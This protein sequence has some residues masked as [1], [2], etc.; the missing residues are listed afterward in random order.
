VFGILAAA[1]VAVNACA[2]VQRVGPATQERA[3]RT[4]L[5]SEARS[6]EG[7]DTMAGDPRPVWRADVGRGI[8][9]G[10]ALTEDL[11]IVAMVDRQ[12]V[13]LERATGD[14]LWRRRLPNAPGAGPLAD[15]DR[16]VVA[17]Q[18][19]D[20]R[21]YALRLANGARIWSAAAGD[22][23]APLVMDDSTVYAATTTGDVLAIRTSDGRRLWRTRLPGAVRAAPL[24]TAAGLVVATATDSLFLLDPAGGRVLVRAGIRGS[25]LA[26][27]TL[28][29]PLVV[30]GTSAGDLLALRADSLTPH[31][32]LDLGGAVAGTVAVREGVAYAL[33]ARG[34]LWHV[35]LDDPRAAG[36][37][38]TGVTAR[39]GPVPTATGVF[40]AGVEGE[41][42]LVDPATGIRRWSARVQ[43]PLLEPPLVDGRFFLVAAARGRVVAF[44]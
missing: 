12:I 26:A 38:E 36:H 22:V 20:G 30:V 33:T 16:I 44:R 28:A 13:V 19:E 6:S 27:P 17:T 29:G 4:Y 24:P 1:L 14:V 15:G 8:V 21:V 25:V 42:A 10:P 11:V 35:P 43:S 40:V 18:E 39:A 7:N 2:S 37:V 41:L 5:G 34:A 23:A 3:W 31:W 9:G 32:R